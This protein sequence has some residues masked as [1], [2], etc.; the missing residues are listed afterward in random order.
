MYM[1]GQYQPTMQQAGG[2]DL[3]TL[4]RLMQPQAPQG[5]MGGAQTV[6]GMQL[7][8]MPPGLPGQPQSGAGNPPSAAPASAMGREKIA[9]ALMAQSGKQMSAA[10]AG[11]GVSASPGSPVSSAMG[12]A[13]QGAQL[14]GL[15]TGKSPM[16]AI[17]N[18]LS[19]G[20]SGGPAVNPLQAQGM[21][22]MSFA[23]MLNGM[24]ADPAL[25]SALGLASGLSP[26]KLAMDQSYLEALSPAGIEEMFAAAPEVGELGSLAGA[27]EGAF[28]ADM[29]ASMGGQEAASAW[30]ANLLA[31]G[32][33]LAFMALI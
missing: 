24:P 32:G 16:S 6:P 21:D 7:P 9:D 12:G 28:G 25:E 18:M 19:P 27:G 29:L 20:A 10:G 33:P 15:I 31:E 8:G 30:L 11:A 1:P 26:D 23:N 14:G 2:M 3:S 13:L 4:M 17:K 5:P 22:Q